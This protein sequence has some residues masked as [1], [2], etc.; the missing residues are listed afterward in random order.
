MPFAWT[1]LQ[2]R[3]GN[4]TPEWMALASATSRRDGT[5][6]F[7]GVHAGPDDRRVYSGGI[8]GCGAS[9]PFHLAP[10]EY[11][12]GVVR[13]QRPGTV[14]GH[15]LDALGKPVAGYRVSLRNHDV[16]TGKQTDGGW[17]NVPTGRDG[18]FTFVGV[19]PGGHKLENND[20]EERA[21]VSE[22][23]DVRPGATVDVTL[24]LKQ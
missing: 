22:V 4:R 16:N 2:E 15:V 19:A 10:G 14:T 24:R 18:R 12:A 8:A 7:A 11:R 13:V 20:H 6:A 3:N 17:R 1:E 23:F 9:E 5:V 21:C